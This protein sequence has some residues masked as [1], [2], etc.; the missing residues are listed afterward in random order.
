MPM[1]PARVRNE[2][3]IL[4]G[5]PEISEPLAPFNRIG[6]EERA[7]AERVLEGGVLSGFIGEPGVEFDG[8][9]ELLAL[10]EAWRRTFG[11]RHAVTVNSA[12]SGLTA[13]MGAARV[14]PG[15]EVILPPYTMSAT[16]MAPLIYGGIPVFADIE[17]E[18]FTIDP[19]RVRQAITDKT[20][21][22]LAVNLFGHPARLGELRAIADENGLVLVEDNAQAPLATEHGRYAGTVGHIGVF[23]LNRHKHIQTGEGGVV[24]SDDDDLALRLKLIRN[25]GENLIEAFGVADLTNL[26]GF[27]YRLTEV[28]AAIGRAQLNKA[29]EII[30][31]RIGYATR[32]SEGLCDLPG[33]TPPVVRERCRHVYYVWPARYDAQVVGASRDAF[34]RALA[35]EGV[36]INQG[37]VKPLHLLPVFQRRI[38]IGRQGFPLSLT[39]RTYAQGLCPIAERMHEKEELGFGICVFE[40]SE[41]IV[42]KLI[43]AFRKVYDNRDRLAGL[44]DAA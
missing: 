34:A 43:S 40:L 14:G 37:Y 39:N 13:A 6:E 4:G 31:E 5:E 27:N 41:A 7:A 8:G 33:L 18:T 10:E 24:V 28:A 17:P 2:L 32:L 12:T 21:A 42:E 44:D 19:E 30:G 38:A 9:P 22:I 11:V 36:P 1:R 23:S 26:V 16:A 15:D 3:A 29:E 35:A 20:R 25:H